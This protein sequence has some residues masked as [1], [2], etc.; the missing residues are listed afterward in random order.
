M[1]DI[2]F[3]KIRDKYSYIRIEGLNGLLRLVHTLGE[4]EMSVFLQLQ[5]QHDINVSVNVVTCLLHSTCA[6]G[7]E[8]E[9]ALELLQG[10]WLLHP[11][12]KDFVS[13][14]GTLDT[15][16]KLI[17]GAQTVQKDKKIA[18]VWRA[19]ELVASL[20]ALISIMVD[21][22]FLQKSFLDGQGIEVCVRCMQNTALGREPRSKCVEVLV[23]IVRYFPIG[24]DVRT[25]LMA[26]FGEQLVGLM[27]RSVR[28]GHA[29]PTVFPGETFLA[30]YD[31]MS[32]K[33]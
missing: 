26:V 23:Y 19:G 12:S 20:D 25:R 28:L 13:S 31:N 18:Q 2:N 15:L 33:M 24:P 7:E 6:L 21:H 32:I 5:D 11:A 1:L 16:L 8:K 27:I 4:Q 22:Q 9:V 10:L 14:I 30:T 17:E 29:D 3:E